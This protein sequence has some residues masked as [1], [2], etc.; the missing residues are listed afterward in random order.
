MTDDSFHHRLGDARAIYEGTHGMT[1]AELTEVTG[2]PSRVLA[3]QKRAEGWAKVVK[4]G[5]TEEAAEAVIRFNEWKMQ[6]AEVN[7]RDGEAMP[8]LAVPLHEDAVHKLLERHKAEL[9]APRVLSQEAI[10]IRHSD[11][12]MAF[13]KA[14]LAK[15]TAETLDILHRAERR[16]FGVK[17]DEKPGGGVVVVERT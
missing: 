16:A 2:I 11:P 14:K 12:N 17:D 8:N 15:I 7:A 10:K 13:Q 1:M 5:Q 9:I 4:S 6:V 3:A